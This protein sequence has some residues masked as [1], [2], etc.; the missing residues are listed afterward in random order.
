[1]VFLNCS[2]LIRKLT[3]RVHMDVAG[4]GYVNEKEDQAQVEE[5]SNVRPVI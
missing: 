3:K 4:V 5:D 1:M 2:M